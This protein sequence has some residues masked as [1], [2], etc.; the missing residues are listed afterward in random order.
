MCVC[1]LVRTGPWEFWRDV[2]TYSTYLGVRTEPVSVRVAMIIYG[3]ITQFSVFSFLFSHARARLF[4]VQLSSD[5]IGFN[6]E[7]QKSSSSSLLLLLLLLLQLCY[8]FF[9]L[10]LSL[11]VKVMI[12][13]IVGSYSCVIL[14]ACLHLCQANDPFLLKSTLK[15][16]TI[17]NYS[18]RLISQQ[19]VSDFHASFT[20]NLTHTHTHSHTHIYKQLATQL[21]DKL[22]FI[23]LY[24]KS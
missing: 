9:P 7:P 15:T 18:S 12:S 16:L 1:V 17:S 13:L 6:C 14:F 2:R 11:Y 8:R 4:L 10:S 21:S 22:I 5:I 19:L 23:F 20:G 24:F 3:T